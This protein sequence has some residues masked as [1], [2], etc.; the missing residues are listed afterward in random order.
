MYSPS[1]F[2]LQKSNNTNLRSPLLN[3]IYISLFMN[4]VL[5]KTFWPHQFC[6]LASSSNRSYILT[7]KDEIPWWKPPLP[8]SSSTCMLI[9]WDCCLFRLYSLF[10]LRFNLSKKNSRI[11]SK[12][13]MYLVY[14]ERFKLPMFIKEDIFLTLLLD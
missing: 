14:Y 6:Y 3:F 11:A 7:Q 1:K 12:S 2:C 10:R 4:K 13:N 5:P 9:N 8:V